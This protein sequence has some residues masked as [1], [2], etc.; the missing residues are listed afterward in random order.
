M[1]EQVKSIIDILSKPPF[2]KTFNII[3][4]DNLE[5]LQL[6]QVLNDVFAYIDSRNKI[7]LR[8]ESPEDMAHRMLKFLS[9]L[10]YTPEC[11]VQEFQAG[12]ITGEKS[13]VYQTL[14][15]V[16]Q[17]V[18]TLKTR[19]YLGRYLVKVEVP[20]EILQDD[21]VEKINQEY[22]EL[23]EEFKTVHKAT[24]KLKSNQYTAAD[25]KKDIQQMEQENEQLT[26]TIERKKARVESMSNINE[27][28]AAA[29]SLRRE[30]ERQANILEQR[31][32]QK[33]AVQVAE[34]KYQRLMI[35]LKE[36]RAASQNM[37]VE[38]LMLKLEE[39]FKSTQYLVEEK[40]PKELAAKKKSCN[41][42]QKVL[43]EPAMTEDDVEELLE[44]AQ[45]L[46]TELNE[47]HQQRMSRTD[48]A[49][50][51][52]V[53]FRK[54]AMMIARKKEALAEELKECTNEWTE[55]ENE[56]SK[57]KEE[58][59][60]TG[61]EQVLTGPEFKKYIAM[62]RNKGNVYKTKRSEMAD[63][64]A[65][66]G[67]LART[68]DI[69]QNQYNEV[70]QAISQM[71]KERGIAGYT[72]TQDK[73][74]M[75]SAAKGET[76]EKKGQ[77]LEDMSD[78]SDKL[79]EMIAEKKA[80][81]APIIKE[82]RPLRAKCNELEHLHTQKKTE[83]DS[84]SASLGS[85]LHNLEQEVRELRETAQ[86]EESRHHFLMHAKQL[87]EAQQQKVEEEL[88]IY[89]NPDP[90]VRKTSLREQYNRKIL[91]QDNL[92]KALRAKQK[93]V[94]EQHTPNVAQ[95]AMWRDLQQLLSVKAALLQRSSEADVGK[96]N[97]L[98]L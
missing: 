98:I 69:L 34:N 64:R 37:S 76:D 49:D 65:E 90:A 75:I 4:F 32:S 42:I 18:E 82:L 71:E 63:L 36:L 62:I 7:D 50:E 68:A 95:M 72:D 94:R 39:E 52:L 31:H 13:V 30:Q 35:Q 73:L 96:E 20:A 57:K 6:L 80:A 54:Q 24:D 97:I 74:E 12:V 46:Q 15:W 83:Y 28:L 91:E 53:M 29:R 79:N 45:D 84:L 17:N 33:T 25:I 51:K 26:K 60:S 88:G 86:A 43:L 5:P 89:K 47:L 77:I 81:L 2:S 93:T 23:L 19:A 59:R 11:S 56:L 8:E 55:A 41:N 87:L 16:L 61:A 14:A 58:M 38:K 48:N 40:L 85:N 22:L 10:K 44:K 66:V 92:G 70:K 21:E 9:V 78:M 67:V 3:S 1:A 27:L